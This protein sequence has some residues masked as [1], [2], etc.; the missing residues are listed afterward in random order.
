M[1]ELDGLE[2][3]LDRGQREALY[4]AG[5]RYEEQ[6]RKGAALRCFLAC[7]RGLETT[8]SFTTLPQCLHKV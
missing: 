5:I 1:P 2:G 7:I 8:E 6:S 4:D 3:L